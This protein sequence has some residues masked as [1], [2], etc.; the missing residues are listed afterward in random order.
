[1]FG[2]HPVLQARC[3]LSGARVEWP[4]VMK[5]CRLAIEPAV[6]LAPM[7]GVTDSPF[8]SVVRGLG[9][10]AV[11]T[12]MVSS[13]G[14][15]RRQAGSLRLLGFGP[16]EHPV[17]AQIFGSRPESMAQAARS[18]QELGFDAVDLNMGC[19]VK[20]VIKS[21]AG[22]AL[23][24]EPQKAARI[25]AAVRRAVSI[26]VLAK[27]RS[28]WS[29]DDIN[30]VDLARR[31]ADCGLDAVTVHP[32]TRNQFYSGSADWRVI[33]QVAAAVDLPVVGNGDLR[34]RADAERM[35]EQTGC[36]GVMVGRAVRGNPWLPGHMAGLPGGPPGPDEIYRV[37]CIHLQKMIDFVGAP[38]P[39]VMRMRKHAVWYTRGVEGAAALRRGLKDLHTAAEM[40]RA[41]AALLC[42]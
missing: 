33:A 12:E 32:R 37:F 18:C 10:P 41:M 34:T 11:F 35:R 24:R 13:E 4:F 15:I 14:I 30:A 16:D 28:G 39:A 20:K 22:A 25:A 1:M 42:S 2:H 7:A 38:S 17:I 40:K 5:L 6:L 3:G 29:P 31:L 27:L 8:R 36:A 23:M 19:P 9:C 21:G 26:P